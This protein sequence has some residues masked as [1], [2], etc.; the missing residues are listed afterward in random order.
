MLVRRI[1]AGGG[2]EESSGSGIRERH[3]LLAWWLIGGSSPNEVFRTL[4]AGVEATSLTS[5]PL[6]AVAE[7]CA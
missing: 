6:V 1:T 2:A 7:C 5:F 4:R 3:I